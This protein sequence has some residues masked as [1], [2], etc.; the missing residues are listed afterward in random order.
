MTHAILVAALTAVGAEPQPNDLKPRDLSPVT[1]LKAPTH[2]PVEIVRDGKARVAV[3]V[4]DPRGYEKLDQKK[5]GGRPQVL[6]QLVDQV[7]E[8]IRLSTG[9]ALER[10]DKPPPAERPAIVIGDCEETRAAG[11]DAAKIPVEG[12]VIKTSP[13]RVYLVGSTQAMTVPGDNEGTA[14][15]VADF[16]ERFVGVRWYWPARY[17]GRSILRRATLVIPPVHYRDQPVF[18]F[19][20]M[21]QDWYWTQ[22]RSFDEELVRLDPDLFGKKTETLWM[23]DHFRLMR[24]GRSWPYDAVQHGARTYEFMRHVPK[25]NKALFAVREEGNRNVDVFCYSDPETLTCFVENLERAWD[26]GGKGVHIG[27]IRRSSVTVWPPMDLGGN[28]LVA[29]CHCTVC[30]KTIAKGG[31]ALVMGRFVQRLCKEVKKRWPDKTVIYVPWDVPDCPEE[32][33]FPGNLVV[34]SLNLD[35][36]GLMHQPLVRREE[37]SKLHA[38]SGKSG[39][40]V[41]MWIDFASPGD[42]T[43]GPVQFPHLVQEFYR[44]NRDR[45]DG[46]MVLTY[47]GACFI[48]AAPTYYV[49]NRVL[50]NPDLDV[51]AVLDEM[52]RRL[53][54]PGADSA[55]E[56]LR[57]QCERWQNTPLS[58]PLRVSEHRIPPKLFR[59]IWTSKVVARMKALR[60]QALAD[61]EKADDAAAR[62]S[63]LYWSWEFDAFADYADKVEEVFVRNT[64]VNAAPTSDESAAAKARFQG[65]TAAVDHARIENVRRQD[66]PIKGQSDIR[67]NLS[68]GHT[69]RAEWTESAA[70]NVT[71][72]DLPVESWSAVWIFA[73]YR[74]ENRDAAKGY[75]HATLSA[76]AE[77]HAAPVAANLDVGLTGGKGMGVFIYRAKTGHGSLELKYVK[78]R[79]LHGIDGVSDPGKADLK[80]FAVE[81]VQVPRGAFKVGSGG[82]ETGSF[83]SGS[84]TGGATLPLLVDAKW[85]GPIAAGSSARRIGHRP[86]WLWGT[87]EDGTAAIGPEGELCDSFPTGYE[88]FYCMRYEVTRSQF[89]AFLNTIPRKVFDATSAGD[90]AHAG[91]HYTAAG[92]YSLSGAWPNLKPAKPYQSCNLLS[93]WDC[94]RFAAWAGLRPI[95]ELEYEKACRGPRVPAANEFAWGTDSIAIDEYTLAND[96]RADE[97]IAA[98]YSTA[99]GN[100]NYDFTMPA[101]HGAVRGGVSV[102]PG[103]PLRAGIFATPDS[104]RIPAGASYWGIMELSGNVR[105]QMVTVSNEKGRLFMGTHGTG[106][107][108][109]PKDWPASGYA[110]KD[111]ALG[112]G[113]RGGFFGDMPSSLRT[114]DRTHAAWRPRPGAFNAAES[115]QDQNG[116]RAVRTAPGTKP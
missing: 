37:E 11:I 112:T 35:V 32:L 51:D 42:W 38:W 60:D 103:S 31:E 102:V 53:F 86:G 52:C 106:T 49:W 72:K 108:S 17:Q 71:G 83:T 54:G 47:G 58:R 110:A 76:D 93:W 59:E 14:W 19:R 27:G 29:S 41:C 56:L 85:S 84:W 114:S 107:P 87:R 44:T 9:A 78:L 4:A 5:R 98:N 48:T 62:K 96:G 24:Q 57:L 26:Q 113:S 61:I 101:S 43:Y 116:F 16:L 65:G 10:L 74:P 88:G 8:T 36:M 28:S 18:P 94:A 33:K 82:T 66:G 7:F 12:F 30:R 81:M 79:W 20:T 34:N 73:K 100:A 95:T 92:R 22:A 39:R 55:R 45:L 115:R 15:A 90:S 1:W 67:F 99:A 97:R 70:D 68:C 64:E 63:F 2:A 75:S 77:D 46:G 89:A 13:K 111:Y 50:W 80:V 104:L 6:K 91:G 69:W 105:E 23:G 109:A 21:Y 25:T 3:Y 40:P